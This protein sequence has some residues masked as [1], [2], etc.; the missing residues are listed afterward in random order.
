MTDPAPVRLEPVTQAILA[1]VP[2]HA[3]DVARRRAEALLDDGRLEHP[4]LGPIPAD[5]TLTWATVTGRTNLR[6]VHGFLFL[7][8]WHATVL[9]DRNDAVTTCAQ[10]FVTWADGH[11]TPAGPEALAGTD[12]AQ[13]A[14]A[15]HDE[16][17]AQRSLHL[18][19]LIIEHW[20]RI[21]P[22]ARPQLQRMLREHAQLLAADW[23]H[24]GENNHGMFQD[25]ALLAL[26]LA[27]ER[28]DSLTPAEV[29]GHAHLA[30]KRLAAYFTASFTEDGV[31]KEN[32][33]GYHLMAARSLRDA[34]PIVQHIRSDLASSLAGTYARAE[35][36]AVHAILPNGRL[37]PLSDT[38]QFNVWPS[39]HSDT[40]TGSQF[41]SSM[42]RG[43][44]GSKPT[45]RT[46]VF[47]TAGYALYRS[48]WS[49]PNAVWLLFKSGYLANYH[50][51]CD[52]L[53]L[54]LYKDGDLV[55]SEA[56]PFGYERDN[57]LTTH[58]FSQWAHNNI[59]MD[60]RSLP[61]T[62]RVP[63]GVG[64]QDLAGLPERARS[65]LDV[66]GTNARSPR[67]THRRGVTVTENWSVRPQL[68]TTTVTDTVE[69]HD[70]AE[71]R[72]EC[73]WHAGPG[74][75]VELQDDTTAVFLKRGRSVLN[76]T[77]SA[78]E[79]LTPAIRRGDA[80]QSPLSVRFPTFG[81][82]AP[83]CVLTLSGTGRALHLTT[84]IR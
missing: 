31:H 1:L 73:L 26:S 15:F 23:F 64:F 40:F 17:T 8:D 72:M 25:F 43:R 28:T 37:P 74:I 2:E 56:G 62:D 19:R 46:A 12:D 59:V 68:V 39:N 58:A 18:S 77:W 47:P 84:R 36:Y 3:A 13:S 53:S 48:R 61:R 30:V 71:H 5:P 24:A 14:M 60:G 21:R 63:R 70:D 7:A 50:H 27:G 55:L 75:T 52:D 33:P 83:G 76:L 9:P 32:S 51:H 35:K 42:T 10:M 41:R 49:D 4:H 81:Q 79:P 11:P 16:T 20:D 54:L 65:V 78:S 67:W 57:P 6:Y 22:G 80:E 38:K 82:T 66:A 29:S 34:L 69:F 44:Y 45:E